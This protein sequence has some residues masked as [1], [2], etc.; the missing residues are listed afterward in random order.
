[1]KNRIKIK[2][3]NKCQNPDILFK[4]LNL[5]HKQPKITQREL[6]NSVGISLWSVHYCIKAIVSISK[7]W[8]G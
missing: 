8:M 3:Q 5:I 7:H 2:T 6:A 4:V 1:M